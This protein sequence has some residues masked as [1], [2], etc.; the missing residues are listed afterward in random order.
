[1]IT[2]DDWLQA[3]KDATAPPPPEDLDTLTINEFAKIIGVQRAQASKRMQILVDA[4]KATVT[5]KAIRRVDGG[6][7]YIP[8]YRLKG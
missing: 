5:R 8:A 6:V 4:G 1:M 2:R 3:L 7:V